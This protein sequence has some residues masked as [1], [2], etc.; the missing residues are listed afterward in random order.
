MGDEGASRRFSDELTSM[1]IALAAYPIL[2]EAVRAGVLRPVA[3]EVLRPL[4]RLARRQG[5]DLRALVRDDEL[6]GLRVVVAQLLPAE[7]PR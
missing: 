6:A 1:P 7:D 3:A 5:A 2:I 4:L